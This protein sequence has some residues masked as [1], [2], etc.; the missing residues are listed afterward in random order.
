MF[1][2]TPQWLHINLVTI[3]DG[4]DVNASRY[5]TKANN[6]YVY[7]TL[8]QLEDAFLDRQNNAKAAGSRI[9]STTLPAD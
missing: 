1:G 6:G 2:G 8:K 4:T 3:P 7:A 5:L 9:R